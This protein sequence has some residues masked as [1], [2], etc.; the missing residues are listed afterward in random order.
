M[1]IEPKKL[2]AFIGEIKE[3][4]DSLPTTSDVLLIS[5]CYQLLLSAEL[6]QRGVIISLDWIKQ[7]VC[8][9]DQSKL[10][11]S[12]NNTAGKALLDESNVPK[13][14]V[15]GAAVVS[16][17]VAEKLADILFSLAGTGK[18]D[19]SYMGLLSDTDSESVLR[20]CEDVTDNRFK[21]LLN[22]GRQTFIDENFD[23]GSSNLITC[24][25]SIALLVLRISLGN[26]FRAASFSNPDQPPMWKR[27]LDL[28]IKLQVNLLRLQKETEFSMEA[29]K[30]VPVES[31][32]EDIYEAYHI[33]DA[34]LPLKN[35]IRIAEAKN[36]TKRVS[37]LSLRLTESYICNTV[38]IQNNIFSDKANSLW[39]EMNSIF[40]SEYMLNEF[41]GTTNRLE[42]ITNG[43]ESLKRFEKQHTET[44]TLTLLQQIL[45]VRVELEH[46]TQIIDI[47][48]KSRLETAKNRT[49]ISLNSSTQQ[50]V[51][52]FKLEVKRDILTKSVADDE[53]V[54]SDYD[55]LILESAAEQLQKSIL[56]IQPALLDQNIHED[57][58]NS[59]YNI[60]E[61][62]IERLVTKAQAFSLKWYDSKKMKKP[63]II[64]S[65]VNKAWDDVANFVT[66][67]LNICTRSID[68]TTLSLSKMNL[69]KTACQTILIVKWMHQ[70]KSPPINLIEIATNYLSN[71]HAFLKQKSIEKRAKQD[72]II[73]TSNEQQIDL[74]LS[75]LEN[76]IWAGRCHLYLSQQNTNS[77]KTSGDY[78]E[79][80]IK[81]IDISKAS[82][83]CNNQGQYGMPFLMCLVSW[84]GFY[85]TPWS[86]CNATTARSITRFARDAIKDSKMEW[87]RQTLEIENLML[88][89]V[90]ADVECGFL[91]GG[92]TDRAKELYQEIIPSIK[93]AGSHANSS[94]LHSHC[95][96]GLIKISLSHSN[97]GVDSYTKAVTDAKDS[98]ETLMLL[99][100]STDHPES[101]QTSLV[102]VDFR[103]SL[104]FHLCHLRTLVAELLIRSLQFADA[105]SFLKEAVAES[106]T[107]F[108]AA[109]ALGAFW[110]RMFCYTS[111]E[112]STGNEYEK[113]SQIQLLKSLKLDSTKAEPFSLLGVWYEIKKDTT[114]AIGCFSK[115]LLIDPSHPVAGRGILRFTNEKEKHEVCRKAIRLSSSTNGWAWKALGDSKALSDG[116]DEE[117]VLF[118]QQ[119]LRCRD[120][121]SSNHHVLGVFFVP[122]YNGMKSAQECTDSWAALASSYRRLGK[123]SAS[124]RAYEIAHAAGGNCDKYMC[125]WAQGK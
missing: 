98:L 102:L 84:S 34:I 54:V 13:P 69:F 101:M 88:N 6:C 56:S 46:E 21:M 14:L 92:F 68:D 24:L 32:D 77:D 83:V 66:P 97:D 10:M 9:D 35:L 99:Q 90:E 100:G 58:Q 122:P 107:D 19:K 26:Q 22:L 33:S 47:L 37:E 65:D 72:N 48:S 11:S 119:A 8:S 63:K 38:G 30:N 61:Q 114:R 109:F 39:N 12:I 85:N 110:L 67:L 87:G 31:K 75:D 106:P 111:E 41:N 57:M 62:H 15:A 55:D 118:Y 17:M 50:S 86:F 3:C 59:I 125:A 52:N 112:L 27:C 53:L 82:N 74:A 42:S 36:N 76:S 80:T 23:C 2:K 78:R 95:V 104:N 116:L 40:I 28:C 115:A 60:L 123:Y 113:K 105:E 71:H 124:L 103:A 20:R 94:L 81:A 93:C 43:K 29:K 44:M 1:S 70:I 96:F 5:K 89:L 18:D 49:G 25:D 91:S 79:I 45:C 4:L 7:K 108:D 73:K 16:S 117:A 120:I 51:D 64:Q 121:E